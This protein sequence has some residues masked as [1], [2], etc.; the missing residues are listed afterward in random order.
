MG[1]ATTC[2]ESARRRHTWN[3]PAR[4]SLVTFAQEVARLRT[5][6]SIS[7]WQ[8]RAATS[9][10]RATSTR[11]NIA[12]HCVPRGV[13]NALALSTMLFPSGQTK[14]IWDQV[15][16]CVWC[17]IS[18]KLTSAPR[19]GTE[20]R[21]APT[22]DGNVGSQ[23]EPC[24]DLKTAQSASIAQVLPAL[25]APHPACTHQVLHSLPLSG[26]G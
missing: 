10:Q 26:P 21:E 4:A 7:A 5:P 24:D 20:T 17:D 6:P 16:A 14:S 2:L 9:V 11:T 22:A 19:P 18:T 1:R 12:W 15:P 23:K 25:P 8:V 13:H 3:S